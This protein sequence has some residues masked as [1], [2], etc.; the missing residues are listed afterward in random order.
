M[1]L[2]C[3]RWVPT[4]GGAGAHARA[5]DELTAE[6]FEGLLSKT[7]APVTEAC[8]LVAQQYPFFALS[9]C[10][11]SSCIIKEPAQKKGNYPYYNMV[12]GLL[13]LLKLWFLGCYPY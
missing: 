1:F 12:T 4:C 2:C 9:V 13:P 11:R 3:V 6:A 10:S 5:S 8:I 7:L